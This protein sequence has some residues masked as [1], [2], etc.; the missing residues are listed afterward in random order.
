MVFS[1]EPQVIIIRPT[2][3]ERIIAWVSSR[4]SCFFARAVRIVFNRFL[5]SCSGEVIDRERVPPY[6]TPPLPRPPPPPIPSISHVHYMYFSRFYRVQTP[7]IERN[8][9]FRNH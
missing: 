9:T 3:S 4:A 2:V 7:D 6:L 1:F 8:T 5:R